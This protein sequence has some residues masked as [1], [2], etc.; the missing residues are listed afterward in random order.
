MADLRS[1]FTDDKGFNVAIRPDLKLPD[2]DAYDTAFLDEGDSDVT[3]DSDHTDPSVEEDDSTPPGDKGTEKTEVKTYLPPFIPGTPTFDPKFTEFFD[4]NGLP[5]VAFDPNKN[6]ALKI[7]VP[8][9]AASAE[10][11]GDYSDFLVT[12]SL[13]Q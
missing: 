7:D 9:P 2:G 1:F 10:P 13:S 12:S 6:Y 11:K 3:D 5:K 4:V 8:I